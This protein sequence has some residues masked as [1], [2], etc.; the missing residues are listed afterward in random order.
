L[1]PETREAE[2]RAVDAVAKKIKA[3]ND[4]E[5]GRLAEG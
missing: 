1:N 4:S 5:R 2:Q 3:R